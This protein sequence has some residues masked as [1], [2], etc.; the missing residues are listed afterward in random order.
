M[1][2][3]KYLT[4]EEVNILKGIIDDK[5]EK[6]KKFLEFLLEK[7][8]SF[9]IIKLC[10]LYDKEENDYDINDNDK[11]LL[12]NLKKIIN[13][14]IIINEE[15]NYEDYR[16]MM[17]IISQDYRVLI[18]ALLI[19]LYDMKELK[20]TNFSNKVKYGQDSLSLYA[21]IAHRLGLG[22]IKSELEELSLYYID[23]FNYK[24][25]S[26]YLDSKK[27]QRE[28]KNQETISH[29]KSKLDSM[30]PNYEIF[31]RSKSLYSIYKKTIRLNKD[32]SDIYDFQGIRII[33]ETKEEC[34]SILGVVHENYNPLPNRFKDY[35]A[36]KKPN[37]YQS[38]HTT[39]S[40]DVGDIFEIQIRTRKMD[41]IAERG[42]AAHWIYKEE[43]NNSLNDVEEQLHLFRDVIGNEKE[44]GLKEINKDIFESTIYTFT[45]NRKIV[46]LPHNATVIDFAFKIHTKV[47]ENISNAIVNDKIVSFNT[48]LKNGDQVKI[49]TKENNNSVQKEWLE[50]VQTSHAKKKIKSYLNNQKNKFDKKRAEEGLKNIK[51]AIANNKIQY[52]IIKNEELQKKVI[53]STRAKDFDSLCKEYYLQNITAKDIN[54]LSE[55]KDILETKT[56]NKKL[57]KTG[58]YVSGI[59]SI[60]ISMAKCC[61]PV[62][63]DDIIG[64]IKNG[65]S[66]VV[67][68][69]DCLRVENSNQIDVYWDEENNNEYL[70]KVYIEALDR[71]QLFNDITN[72][73]SKQ[74]IS[75][76]NINSK[77]VDN[78]VR[79]KL[80]VFVKNKEQLKDLESSFKNIDSVIEVGQYKN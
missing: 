74:K 57:N 19:R 7:S 41:E 60:K 10:L 4:K 35:I 46:M 48:V 44:E 78:V 72:T 28:R 69:K 24:K 20:K 1:E 58:V 38:L 18:A 2:D 62:Y 14:D 66:I 31:G 55:D 80:E 17:V 64:A 68:K 63:G 3:K 39:V 76:G 45:P 27:S 70:A 54:T 51:K 67:H 15:N 11:K 73:L 13:I 49:L 59:D 52:D 25:I 29:I 8:M 32:F 56:V 9:D 21:P 30:I 53:K 43:N 6:D 33:C 40:N 65:E 79:T 26:N 5:S 47:G 71:A 34:Y 23:I 12:A 42:I 77:V 16:N 75:L 50:F 37:L 36:L 61:C 22:N